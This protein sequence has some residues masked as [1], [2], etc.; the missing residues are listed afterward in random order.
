MNRVPPFI[1]GAERVLRAKTFISAFAN[2][3]SRG[4][5]KSGPDRSRAGR[6]ALA[7]AAL[8]G[9]VALAP[10]AAQAN[11]I[12]LVE[13]ETGRVLEQKDA[14]KPWYPASVTKLMTT[15]VAL[16]AV[17]S[18]RLAMDTPITVS[19]NA[20]SQ[21]PSKMGFKPGTKVTLEDALKMLMVKSANDIAV[22]VAEGVGGSEEEFVREMNAV[23]QHL[24]MS[25]TH[26][27]NPH[28][29]PNPGQVT[30][31]RDMALL[32]RALIYHFPEYEG[33]FRI[34]SIK[35]GNRVLRNYNRLIDRY[36]GAD[37]MKTGFICDSGFNLVATA[38]RGNRR[39]I[40]VVF[41]SHSAK[42]RN[43]D[44]ALLLEKGFRSGPSLS[45]FSTTLSSLPNEGGQPESMRAEVCGAKRNTVAAEN[46]DE[47]PGGQTLGGLLSFNDPGLPAS[48][49]ELLQKLPPSMPPVRVS[50]D[51][52]GVAGKN[53]A[54]R[55][56]NK[57]SSDKPRAAAG[58]APIP[59]SRPAI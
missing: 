54:R 23:A 37:G 27:A 31:A 41:G 1:T 53:T 44:A 40:A 57:S 51:T 50:A 19:R 16:H 46:E 20:A 38:T 29:L 21:Q 49:A 47:Q 18:G 10:L 15:Y 34:P 59:P 24:G 33:L 6:P 35:I 22:T 8:A 11:P 26:F 36:P 17:K 58:G 45:F 13:A 43:E 52:S 32:V 9:V 3:W 39:L 28:G 2:A 56:S 12:L 30:T 48:G 42:G 4:W 25:G 7:L 14:G 5:R 55:S